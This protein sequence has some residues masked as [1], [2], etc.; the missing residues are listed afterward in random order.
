M[1]DNVNAE[2]HVIPE[3]FIIAPNNFRTV[4][5]VLSEAKWMEILRWIS[6]ILGKSDRFS[7]S[8]AAE[9]LWCMFHTESTAKFLSGQE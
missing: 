7:A 9:I 4:L 2:L 8:L 1:D 6:K 5:K 3:C